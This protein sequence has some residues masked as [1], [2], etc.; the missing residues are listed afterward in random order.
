MIN[1]LEGPVTVKFDGNMKEIELLNEN[2]KFRPDNYFRADSYQVFLKSGGKF[3]WDGYKR[4]F[5]FKHN[6]YFSSRGHLP[7]IKECANEFGIELE[8]ACKIDNPFE[9]IT[10]D[11]IP[12]DLLNADLDTEQWKLQKRC[13]LQWLNCGIGRNKVTVSGGKTA[14]FCAV[15]AMIKTRFPTARF[16]YITPSERLVNQVCIEAKRF[17][18]GWNISQYG[19]KRRDKDGRDMVIVTTAILNRNFK[20]LVLLGWFRTFNC[21]LADEAQ[22]LGTTKI[23]AILKAIPAYYRFGASDTT[24]E[25]DKIK[26]FLITGML[27]PVFDNKIDAG[28]LIKLDKIAKPHIYIIDIPSWKNK[29]D[30]GHTADIGTSAWVLNDNKWLKGIYKGNVFEVGND[31]EF[32]RDRKDNNVIVPGKH[33]IEIDG[34]ETAVDSRWCLL[35]RRYDQAVIKFSERNKLIAKWAKFFSDKNMP[36]L[37]IATRTLHI[38]ILEAEINKIVDENKV[39]ILFSMSSPK[40]RDEAFEWFKT[41]PGSIL[42]TPLVKVGVSINEIKAEIVADVISDK[43]YAN[44][45]IGRAIRKKLNGALNEAHIVWFIERQEKHLCRITKSLINELK[46]LEGYEFYENHS[47]PKLNAE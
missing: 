41:T 47:L 2:L 14:M 33:L 17:L 37:I 36:T 15:A 28:T 30:L 24:K 29:Y 43:E 38:L 31:G 3:G 23:N 7:A 18:P 16:I 10:E 22:F 19:G 42:I 46:K 8:F 9:N 26:N 6:A 5:E 39:R 32:I 45:I 1:I 25:D 4:L 40:E 12:D 44:Q 20:K 34:I 35:N 13:I 11:D 27:G 21:I